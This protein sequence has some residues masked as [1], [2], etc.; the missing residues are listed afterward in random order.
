MLTYEKVTQADLAA[1]TALYEKYLNAG[2]WVRAYLRNGFAREDYIGIKCMDGDRMAGIFSCQPGVYFTYPHHELEAKV[3]RRWPEGIYSLDMVAIEADYRGQGIAHQIT[4]RC[5]DLL[6][7]AG[8]AY[9]LAE[10]WI[11]P[12]GSMPTIG[13]IK[14]MGSGAFEDKWEFLD[15]YKDLEEYKITCPEC[16]DG[17]C[18]CGA[19]VG[20]IKL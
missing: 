10:L 17:P 7:E 20:V 18:V 19:L 9:L 8:V 13:I 14:Y 16:G 2:E 12:D 11:K 15:F 3:K 6:K 4:K 5:S 1:A